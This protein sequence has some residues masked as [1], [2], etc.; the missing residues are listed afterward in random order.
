MLFYI[1]TYPLQYRLEK[2]RLLIETDHVTFN[3]IKN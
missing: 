3:F 2:N 1:E